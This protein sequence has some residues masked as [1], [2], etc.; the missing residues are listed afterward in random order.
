[1][2]V[3]MLCPHFVTARRLSYVLAMVALSACSTSEYAG[4]IK[5]FSD[6]TDSATASMKKLNESLA[7]ATLN[8]AV[9]AAARDPQNNSLVVDGCGAFIPGQETRCTAT[10]EM[11][12]SLSP[13][14]TMTLERELYTD[15][16]GG[17]VA[18]M[19]ALQDYAKNLAALQSDNTVA[20]VNESIDNVQA[21]LVELVKAAGGD[22]PPGDLPKAAGELVKWAFGQYIE[23]VKYRALRDATRAATKPLRLA[24][25]AFKPIDESVKA[26][27][28]VP[29]QADAAESLKNM[30]EEDESS[31]R[32][33][34]AVQNAY[35]DLLT[36]P[37]S[38]MFDDLVAAHEDLA[39]SL[40]GTTPLSVRGALA[41]LKE[42][43]KQAVTLAKIATDLK[44]ALKK[45]PSS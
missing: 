1:M 11:K 13:P 31:I 2:G 35:D 17:M 19:V 18:I 22:E 34:L 3:E 26:V 38:Q 14:T 8:Y 43:Q 9:A 6:A 32:R 23:S 28:T 7:E 27:L 15:P 30:N 37:M 39:S 44:A 25:V 24:A 5:T 41:K 40:D 20:E 42:V 16:L 4:P 36:A 10:F 33:T 21:S 45:P 29:V 12:A